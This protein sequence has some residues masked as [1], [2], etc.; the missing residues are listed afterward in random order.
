MVKKNA[1]LMKL[2]KR[3]VF[4]ADTAGSDLEIK[5]VY[6]IEAKP[7]GYR[8]FLPFTPPGHPEP[9]FQTREERDKAFDWMQA[10]LTD[11][12]FELEIEA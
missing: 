6:I 12:K 3:K 11:P 2:R 1:T 9:C 4:M 8:K 7:I 5:Q 10:K